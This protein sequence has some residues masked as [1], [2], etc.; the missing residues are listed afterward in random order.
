MIAI[1]AAMLTW[2]T[3]A[4]PAPDT[5]RP[6]A[7]AYMEAYQA[8]DFEVLSGL[9][10]EDAI[11][12]DPTSFDVAPITSPIRWQGSDAIIDGIQG[13]S[14]TSMRYTLERT[15]EASGHVIYDGISDVEFGTP[16]GAVTYRFP[17]I[18]IIT[19]ENGQ[20]TEHRDYTD[21][22]G[23]QRQPDDGTP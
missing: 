23:M 9:Y 7:D 19:V 10:A 15:Y 3:D 14:V 13:W 17:I 8:Q 2:Q 20:A 11:F 22:A 18:T 1:L 4:P 21:Y 12:V 6:V 16:E 5:V